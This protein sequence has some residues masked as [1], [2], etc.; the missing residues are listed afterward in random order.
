MSASAS[1]I[2]KHRNRTQK[3]QKHLSIFGVTTLFSDDAIV[4]VNKPPGML[5]VPSPLNMSNVFEEVKKQFGEIH[6]V[7]R[8]DC[9]TSGIMVFARHKEALRNLHQQFRDRTVNKVYEALGY[10]RCHLN[11]GVIQLPLN[12][13]WP[14]RPKQKLDFMNGKDSMT[15]WTCLEVH[16]EHTR[17]RLHPITGRTHQLRIHL[18]SIGHSILGDK[19][20]SSPILPVTDVLYPKMCLHATELTFKHPK[21]NKMIVF[22]S[23]TPF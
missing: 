5:S 4:V 14:K 6:I 20:Y 7:H 3:N 23:Q 18:K 13:D 22:I 19:L 10:G 12:V 15:H 16:N 1:I 9:E 21:S 2:T 8:L 17:F 11:G